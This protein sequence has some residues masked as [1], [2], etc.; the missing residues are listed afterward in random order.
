M[1]YVSAI[2]IS[3]I[4]GLCSFFVIES[5]ITEKLVQKKESIQKSIDSLRSARITA[6]KNNYHPFNLHA[7]DEEFKKELIQATKA[8]SIDFM[9]E[10]QI[11][12]LLYEKRK[13]E[14]KINH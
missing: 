12:S 1:K 4:I 10:F 7:T 8:D 5:A 9:F 3:V 13:I 11:K 14:E 2:F 6:S